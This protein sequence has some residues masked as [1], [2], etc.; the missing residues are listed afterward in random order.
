M[1]HL[2]RLASELHTLIGQFQYEDQKDV[3]TSQGDFH[4]DRRVAAPSTKH[5]GTSASRK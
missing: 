3:A 5:R 4:S 1:A 2:A